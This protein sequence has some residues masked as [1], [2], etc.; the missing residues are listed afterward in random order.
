MAEGNNNKVGLERLVKAYIAAF[1]IPE[2]LDHYA[3]EDFEKAQREF[4]RHCLQQGRVAGWT[5]RDH[6][7]PQEQ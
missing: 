7:K 5:D 3:P 1:R 2:N 4:I 6:A